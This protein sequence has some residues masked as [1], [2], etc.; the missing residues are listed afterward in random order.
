VKSL[1]KP[2]VPGALAALLV[3]ACGSNGATT[4]SGTNSVGATSG[5]GGS[6]GSGPGGT[7]GA[8]GASTAT[9][10]AG[11]AGSTTSTGTGTGTGGGGGSGGFGTVFTIL[12]ENHDYNEIVGSADA[13]YLNSLIGTYGLATNYQDSGKHPSLPNYLYLISG[14][15]Q[16]PGVI[17]VN[18]DWFPYFPSDADNLG[19]QLEVAGVNWRSYQEDMGAACTLDTVG[20]YAPKHDPFVYF[21]NIQNNAALCANRNVDYSQ[22]PADLAA[23]TFQYMWITPNLTND[24]HDPT[25]DPKAA[26]KQ[27]DL[28]LGVEVPKILASDAYKK[29]GVLF[30]TWDEAEGRNGN[31]KDQVPMIVISPKLKSPGMKVAT[32]LSH[33]SYLA[34]IEEIHGLPKL[35]AAQSAT[36]LMEFFSP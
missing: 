27:S 31:S 1:L 5:V 16:Y 18:P 25:G 19:H 34:T 13:P 23:G 26:L 2:L 8:G 7:G 32:A 21:K 4:G 20:S 17:D 24:G 10:G 11:G 36:S 29:N 22:F 15:T 28:W 9:T 12:L 6:G 14:D 3:S 33:A 30:I 35:G